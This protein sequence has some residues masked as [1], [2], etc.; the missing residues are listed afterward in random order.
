MQKKQEV[1]IANNLQLTMENKVY[2]EISPD[3]PKGKGRPKKEKTKVVG[4]R[5]PLRIEDEF[6][7]HAKI[8]T[9]QNPT[10]EL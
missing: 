8:F 3:K 1:E 2:M 9:D 10:F 4:T 7:A 5:V 6:R